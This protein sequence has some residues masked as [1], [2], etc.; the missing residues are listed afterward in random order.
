MYNTLKQY[1][2]E[3]GHCLVPQNF[4]KN[5]KLGR[6][7]KAQ[8]RHYKL[9][10][11][12]KKSSMTDERVRLLNQIGFAWNAKDFKFQPLVRIPL[13]LTLKRSRIHKEYMNQRT[14]IAEE[15]SKLLLQ[16]YQRLSLWG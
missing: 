6:F 1:E 16:K 12:R 3:N 10:T 9:M 13:E 5:P 14:Y 8:R 2:K 15:E 4:E 7:V 11:M